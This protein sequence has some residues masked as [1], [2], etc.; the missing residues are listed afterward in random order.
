MPTLPLPSLEIIEEG[1]AYLKSALVIEQ[2]GDTKLWRPACVLAGFSME[3]FLK[4]FLAKDNSKLADTINGIDIYSGAVKSAR[5]HFLDT[6]IF[7]KITPE[8]RQAI[9]DTSE[10]LSPGYP[11][12]QK[13]SEYSGYFF[14]GRYGY[15]ANA[16]D[17]I[18]MEV[19]DAAEHLEKVCS[20]LITKIYQP[21]EL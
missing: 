8:W 14:N 12:E 15:E 9:L 16:I 2:A 20:K 4:S 19:L 7:Q 10:R 18:R 11:L 3:L 6:D 5:G 1:R 21:N 13:L 17:V